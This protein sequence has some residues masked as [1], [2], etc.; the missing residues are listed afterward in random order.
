M[1]KPS[2]PAR[3]P[4]CCRKNPTLPPELSAYPTV[5]RAH[6]GTSLHIGAAPTDRPLGDDFRQYSPAAQNPTLAQDVMAQ[7]GGRIDLILDGGPT[8]GPTASTVADVTTSEIKNLEGRSHFPFRPPKSQQIGFIMEFET[9]D[10]S[11]S[12]SSLSGFS[13][14][15]PVIFLRP[16][17]RL[18]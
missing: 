4:S 15:D 10:F 8:P 13:P 12:I 18:A 9:K 17:S 3:S 1:P 6:A 5:G 7:L 14:C 16:P 2:G 11:L